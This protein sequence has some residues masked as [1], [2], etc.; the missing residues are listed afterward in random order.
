MTGIRRQPILTTTL[1]HNNNATMTHAVTLQLANED[2]RPSGPPN[3][4]SCSAGVGEPLIWLSILRP[5][6]IRT[7]A[8]SSQ[9]L[10]E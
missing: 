2:N 7:S 9:L 1:P 8:D 10:F 3:T 4:K 5:M 6:V